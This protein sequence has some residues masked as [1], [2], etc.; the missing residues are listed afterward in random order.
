MSSLRV[1][2][3]DKISPFQPCYRCGAR[4]CQWDRIGP[5]PVC[6]D[7]AEALI[8]G[9]AEPLSEPLEKKVCA[10]CGRTG[11]VRFLTFP[12]REPEPVEIDLCPRHFRDLLGRRLSAQAFGVL[13]RK[14]NALGFAVEQVFLLHEAFY[15]EDGQALHPVL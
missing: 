1:V 8:A 4:D 14:L 6:P 11:T 3:G 9:E 15:D 13:R 2:T 5:H 7:C 10:V 12:L